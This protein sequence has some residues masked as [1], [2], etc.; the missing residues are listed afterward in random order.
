MITTLGW[1]IYARQAGGYPYGLATV[2]PAASLSVLALV[3]VSLLTPRPTRE[4]LAA[5]S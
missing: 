2:Y 5:I 4:E 1:E 3:V